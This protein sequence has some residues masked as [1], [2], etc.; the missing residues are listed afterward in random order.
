[1]YLSRRVLHYIEN[2]GSPPYWFD[3]EV[4]RWD[5]E[6]AEIETAQSLTSRPPFNSNDHMD[7]ST[8]ICFARRWMDNVHTKARVW[9]IVKWTRTLEERART[10]VTNKW[11]YSEVSFTQEEAEEVVYNALREVMDTTSRNTTSPVHELAK[12]IFT[13]YQRCVGDTATDT[14]HDLLRRMCSNARR[15]DDASRQRTLVWN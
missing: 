14:P 6:L 3:P 10:A 1:M 12:Y 5:E 15:M 2:V 7:H 11:R 4:S 9:A 8:S 13:D